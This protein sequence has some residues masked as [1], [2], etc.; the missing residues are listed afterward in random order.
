M[1]SYGLPLAQQFQLKQ[2]QTS[3]SAQEIKVATPSAHTYKGT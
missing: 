2:N 1:H 3:I